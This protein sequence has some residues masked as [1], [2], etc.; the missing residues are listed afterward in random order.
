MILKDWE[1][2][3]DFCVSLGMRLASIETKG[4]F[5]ALNQK[6]SNDFLGRKQFK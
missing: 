3:R 6:Y 5:D 4:Q 2:S 1:Q